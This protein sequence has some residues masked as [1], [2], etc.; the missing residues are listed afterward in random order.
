MIVMNF[1][2]KSW[3]DL[4]VNDNLIIDKYLFMYAKDFTLADSSLPH[5]RLLNI[6][7]IIERY[8]LEPFNEYMTLFNKAKDLPYHNNQHSFDVFL[9][10]FEG[11]FYEQADDTTMRGALAGAMFH[12]FNHSGGKETDAMNIK[13]ALD[14]LYNAQSYAC[15]MMIGL[16][17]DELNI[18]VDTIKITEFPFKNPPTKIYERVI[19]DA[20][21]MQA[22]ESSLS[23]LTNQFQGLQREIQL[24]TGVQYTFGIFMG[25]NVDFLN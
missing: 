9:N 22:Y 23:V 1:V 25:K 6:N 20:D 2:T 13:H 24:S 14:G 21:L 17:I 3:P 19:R 18:A 16:S 12:D 8:N 10:T 7:T 4:S 15:S 11:L 5:V